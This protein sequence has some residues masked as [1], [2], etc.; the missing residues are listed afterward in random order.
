LCGLPNRFHFLQ[1]Q[2]GDGAACLGG[3]AL[4]VAE[5]GGEALGHTAQGVL[6]VYLQV[7]GDVDEGLTLS[8]H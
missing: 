1:T 3:A 5:A 8:A 4:D 7:A 2:V 6:G